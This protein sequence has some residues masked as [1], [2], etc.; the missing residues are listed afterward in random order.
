MQFFRIPK[1]SILNT[2]QGTF[3]HQVPQCGW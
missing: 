3:D 1:C 2:G